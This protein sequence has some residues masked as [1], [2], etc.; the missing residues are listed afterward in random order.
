MI[1]GDTSAIY[2]FRFADFNHATA[3]GRLESVDEY[4]MLVP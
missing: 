1:F 2:A 3:L 4:C